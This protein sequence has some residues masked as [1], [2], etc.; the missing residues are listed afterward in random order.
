MKLLTNYI[1]SAT[2]GCHGIGNPKSEIQNPKQIQNLS[3]KCSKLDK[4]AT[5]FGP[6][7]FG[8]GICFEFRVSSFEF[9]SR[10]PL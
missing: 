9:L 1:D 3:W 8:F 6:L 7:N 10:A 5:S 2:G 4:R